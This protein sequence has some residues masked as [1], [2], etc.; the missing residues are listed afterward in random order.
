MPF[1]NSQEARQGEKGHGVRWVLAIS[2][3][4]AAIALLLFL[5]INA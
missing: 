1:L 5:A 3:A 4:G 2:T